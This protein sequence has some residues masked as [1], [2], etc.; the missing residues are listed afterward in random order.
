MKV[1]RDRVPKVGFPAGASP[2]VSGG[3]KMGQF[4]YGVEFGGQ[5]RATTMQFRPHANT[6]FGGEGYFFYPILREHGPEFVV[7]WFEVIMAE[8]AEDWNA[9]AAKAL[10][11]P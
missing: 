9:G 1:Y 6:G 11:A 7:E 10:V 5:N 4:F 3:A 8:M 2:G